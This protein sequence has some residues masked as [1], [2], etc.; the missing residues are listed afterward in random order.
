MHETLAGETILKHITELCFHG[1]LCYYDLKGNRWEKPWSSAFKM[2]VLM[3]N[4]VEQRKLHIDRL[5]A[6]GNERVTGENDE[7]YAALNNVQVTT[8]DMRSRSAT[9]THG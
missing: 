3:E 9:L 6:N 2:E 7:R 1:D 4:M 5:V 8:D